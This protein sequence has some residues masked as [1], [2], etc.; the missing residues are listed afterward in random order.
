MLYF[1]HKGE[2]MKKG[3][4]LTEV[5]IALGII[6]VVAAITIPNLINKIQDKQYDIARKKV[7]ATVG[8]SGR[9]ITI[10]GNMNSGINAEDFVKN[11]LS[12]KLK[13]IKMC[14]SNNL[15]QCGLSTKF[16]T[17]DDSLIN[18]PKSISQLGMR[19]LPSE[20]M[21]YAEKNKPSYGFLMSNGYSVNIFYNPNCT[22]DT[23]KD[24]RSASDYICLNAIFDVNGLK[25][26][27]KVGKDIGFLSVLYNNES[28]KVVAPNVISS[29]IAGLTTPNYNSGES[30]NINYLYANCNG[31]DKNYY[32]PDKDELLSMAYNG[33]LINLT[34]G[35]FLSISSASGGSLWHV[36]VEYARRLPGPASTYKYMFRC[37]KR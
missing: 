34:Q 37:I 20:S 26:P 11:Q 7:I 29:K 16:K 36:Y 13:I 35:D 14:D 3:F 18:M 27:N 30:W 25:K 8:E 1:V 22:V 21:T 6:G 28:S 10:E 5:L 17:T 9:L 24:N 32:P 12:K 23:N 4:T 19:S 31:I 33:N 2:A 15:E